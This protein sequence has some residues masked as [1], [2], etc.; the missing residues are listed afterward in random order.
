MKMFSSQAMDLCVRQSNLFLAAQQNTAR[1]NQN[2]PTVTNSNFLKLFAAKIIMGIDRKPAMRHY[3]SRILFWVGLL[4]R[5]SFQVTDFFHI[6]Q[7]L[8]FDESNDEEDRIHKIR[9]LWELLFKNFGELNTPYENICLD[10]SLIL[11][12]LFI[13]VSLYTCEKNHCLATHTHTGMEIFS[14]PWVPLTNLNW[15]NCWSALTFD[16]FK[17]FL[18]SF[19][20]FLNQRLGV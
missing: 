3:W 10:E 1:R 13:P 2:F 9:D 14:S 15:M 12:Y 17:N 11:F 8:H 18:H 4:F 6:L 16:F 7:F 5:N 20:E 19:E